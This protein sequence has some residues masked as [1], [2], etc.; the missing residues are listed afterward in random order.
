MKRLRSFF[1]L[2]LIGTFI[3]SCEK[4]VDLKVDEAEKKVAVEGFITNWQ[5][6][7]Y[8]K[9]SWTKAYLSRHL[10]EP[11][12]DAVVTVTDGEGNAIVFTESSPGLY[13]CPGEF[14]GVGGRTYHLEIEHEE[15]G[16]L[17]AVSTMPDTGSVQ[18]L[19]MLK[20]GSNDPGMMAGYYLFGTIWNRLDVDNYHRADIFVNGERRIATAGDIID[21]RYFENEEY[22]KGQFSFWPE[23]EEGQPQAGDS[24]SLRLYSIDVD[25]YN[26]L[27]ALSETPSQGGLF[28]K[29]PANVPSNIEGGLGLFQASSY[30]LSPVVSV[31][32]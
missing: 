15:A 18:S 4:K 8:V 14:V 24:I 22:V 30:T 2:I 29:N 25:A 26:Y 6:E 20:V 7:S 10:P 12:S 19:E 1:A 5:N 31:E 17:Y 16:R 27:K 3:S 13:T 11:V 28:G 9:L 21:D 32:E 23:G